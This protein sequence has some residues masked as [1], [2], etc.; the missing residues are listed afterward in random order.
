MIAR[1]SGQALHARLV[2]CLLLGSTAM[3]VRIQTMTITQTAKSVKKDSLEQ[4]VNLVT[5][6]KDIH[7]CIYVFPFSLRL[8]LEINLK[9]YVHV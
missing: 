1:T 6:R 2:R 8:S 5:Y 3:L 4:I 7:V 9:S